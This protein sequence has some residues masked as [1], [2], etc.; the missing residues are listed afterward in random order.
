MYSGKRPAADL[1]RQTAHLMLGQAQV[2][3]NPALWLSPEEHAESDLT[4]GGGKLVP[5]LREV[6]S[7]RLVEPAIHRMHPPDESAVIASKHAGD[8]P[9]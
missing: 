5:Q 2:P 8:C 1:G 3:C 4:V 6:Q 9:S 7:N